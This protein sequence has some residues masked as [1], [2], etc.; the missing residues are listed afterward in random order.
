MDFT[1]EIPPGHQVLVFCTQSYIMKISIIEKSFIQKKKKNHRV[2]AS[3]PDT[4]TNIIQDFPGGPV[5]KIPR[6]QCRRPG[7]DSW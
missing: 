6:S 4:K 7:F 2:D 1:V 5:T 3:H